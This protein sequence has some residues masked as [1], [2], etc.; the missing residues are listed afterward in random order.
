MDDL[1]SCEAPASKRLRLPS[2]IRQSHANVPVCTAGSST[3]SATSTSL[4]T[5]SAACPTS[6][7]GPVDTLLSVS[8]PFAVSL[9][10]VRLVVHGF[11]SDDD[12]VRLLRVSRTVAL[13]L[14]RGF[15]FHEHVFCGDSEGQLWRLKRLWEKYDLCPTRMCLSSTVTSLSLD[16]DSGLSPFPSSLKS[17]LLGPLP[18][19]PDRTPYEDTLFDSAALARCG[20]IQCLWSQADQEGSDEAKMQ[21]L[22]SDASL[23]VGHFAEV[24]GPFNCRLAPGLLP[25][26]LRYLHFALGF[27]HPLLPG[28]IPSTVEV[29]QMDGYDE[30]LMVAWSQVLPA[31]LVH[32]SMGSFTR[33]LNPGVF[34]PSLERVRLPAWKHGFLQVGVLPASVRALD[35]PLAYGGSFRRPGKWL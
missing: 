34:P 16:E 33:P 25:H 1:S 6:V 24:E 21:L 35:A 32:L 30:A 7:P 22:S 19:S 28:S 8:H 12:A 9:G 23:P 3:S 17:L 31:S 29:L 20:A 11:L 2:S 10:P 14:L 15:T 4:T 27:I 18:H 5:V 26:G 13:A